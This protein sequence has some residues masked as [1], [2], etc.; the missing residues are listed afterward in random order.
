MVSYAHATCAQS[1]R[2]GQHMRGRANLCDAKTGS[3]KSHNVIKKRGD[4]HS[5]Y[6]FTRSIRYAIERPHQRDT[7]LHH[8]RSLWDQHTR[9]SA[10][11]R[12]I[13]FTKSNMM[14]GKRQRADVTQKRVHP[15]SALYLTPVFFWGPNWGFRSAE[16][17]CL[18]CLIRLRDKLAAAN[19]AKI[20]WRFRSA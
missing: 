3:Q 14:M 1:H 20:F 5:A 16:T 6:L 12:E 11:Q 18:Q 10:T 9:G 8:G 17:E 7:P 4:L 2:H 15:S 19:A 13:T